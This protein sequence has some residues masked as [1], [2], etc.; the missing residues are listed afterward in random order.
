MTDDP[1]FFADPAIDRVMGVVLAMAT[2]LYVTRDRLQ[3]LEQQLA[4]SGHLDRAQLDA[5]PADRRA[6]QSRRGLRARPARADPGSSDLI[7]TSAASPP[8]SNSS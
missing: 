8:P 4:A 2:E 5:A 7:W 3:A 1:T 6:P